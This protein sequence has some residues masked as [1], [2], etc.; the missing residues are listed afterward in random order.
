MITKMRRIDLAGWRMWDVG[1]ETCCSQPSHE[2]LIRMNPEL[3]VIAGRS[4]SRQPINAR[5]GRREWDS[6]DP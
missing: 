4:V 6:G 1:C 2:S 3:R 5:L